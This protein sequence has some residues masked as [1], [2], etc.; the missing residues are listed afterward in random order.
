MEDGFE[1][2]VVDEFISDYGFDEI[3]YL[4]NVDGVM[5]L[6]NDDDVRRLI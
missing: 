6:M 1:F 5:I 3:Y 4:V 2:E